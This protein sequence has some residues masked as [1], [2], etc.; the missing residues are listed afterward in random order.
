MIVRN[1]RVDVHTYNFSWKNVKI[2]NGRTQD[3][4]AD[5]DL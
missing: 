5:K 2:L 1:D 3:E 4:N